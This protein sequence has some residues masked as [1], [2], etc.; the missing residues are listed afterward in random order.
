MAAL[1]LPGEARPFCGGSLINDRYVMTAA[2]CVV[3]TRPQDTRVILGKHELRRNSSTDLLLELSEVKT[4]PL[5]STIFLWYD[6]AL[7]KLATPLDLPIGGNLIAPVCLPYRIPYVR[8]PAVAAGWG[9]TEGGQQPERLRA[10][11]LRTVS[12]LVCGLLNPVTLART[13]LCATG[14][15]IAGGA[16]TCSGDSGGPLTVRARWQPGRRMLLGLTSWGIGCALPLA[17]G[18][19]AKVPAALDWI[20]RNT[21]DARYC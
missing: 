11:R 15:L 16:D 3:G 6:Y 21:P 5:F 7:L 14:R 8:E 13:M 18:V 4:H 1:V 10:V 12:S 20:V 2:H 17:P 9:T 19:Y